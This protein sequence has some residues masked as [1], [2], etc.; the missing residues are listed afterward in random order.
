MP[1]VG[2]QTRIPKNKN[3]TKQVN[4]DLIS[5]K[6]PKSGGGGRNPKL[7]RVASRK[8]GKNRKNKD[9]EWRKIHPIRFPPTAIITPISPSPW[10]QWKKNKVMSAKLVA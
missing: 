6:I 2:T 8:L 4:M 1:T 5:P 7:R 9:K 10:R 3:N